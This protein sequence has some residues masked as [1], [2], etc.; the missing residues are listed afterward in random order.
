MHKYSIESPLFKN[1]CSFLLRLQ[2]SKDGD[3]SELSKKIHD[4]EATCEML[5]NKKK[6]LQLKCDAEMDKVKD[7]EDEIEKINNNVI[8][9]LSEDKLRLENELRIEKEKWKA[10]DDELGRER[11]AKDEALLR[12]AQIS[13]EVNMAQHNLRQQQSDVEELMKRIA[14]LESQ[15]KNKEEVR[16]SFA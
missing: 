15:L 8:A 1:A 16:T 14:G 5:R 10:T 12:N 2:A 13:Q 6:D 11:L 9:A 7:L 4:V 3:I